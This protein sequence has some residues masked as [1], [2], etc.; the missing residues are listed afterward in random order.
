VALVTA[1]MSVVVGV[2]PSDHKPRSPYVML[3]LQG[4]VVATLVATG[5]SY[6]KLCTRYIN[7][8]DALHGV[9]LF[10]V[11]SVLFNPLTNYFFR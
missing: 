4:V 2:E 6:F 3:E 7:N 9:G 8:I 11:R 1:D 10:A 5:A